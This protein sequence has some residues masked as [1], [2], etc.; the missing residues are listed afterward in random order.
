MLQA[1][2]V[3]AEHEWGLHDLASSQNQPLEAL[4]ASRLVE[5]VGHAAKDAHLVQPVVRSRPSLGLASMVVAALSALEV[6]PHVADL[7]AWV[8]AG[9]VEG[10]VAIRGRLQM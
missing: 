1:L 10:Q 4:W 8:A 2:Q 7:A 9:L 5:V 6:A 3:E